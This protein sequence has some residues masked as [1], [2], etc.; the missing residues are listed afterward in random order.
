[1]KSALRGVPWLASLSEEALD[2]V[3]EAGTEVRVPPG[4]TLMGELEAGDDL[5]ILVEG[6]ARATVAAGQAA[7]LQLGTLGP[8][9]T[10]GELSLVTRELRS[11]TVTAE[12]ELQALRIERLEFEQLLRRH[13]QIAA[14]FAREVA[15]RL[16][17]ADGALDAML[18]RGAAAPEAQRLT[19]RMAAVT[20]T[21]GSLSRA[22]RELVVSRWREPPFLAL[23][24]FLITLVVIRLAVWAA[25]AAGVPLFALLRGAYTSGFAL[26]LISTATSLMRFRPSTRRW[27]A[28]GCGIGFALIVNELSVFLAFD[29]FYVD[30]TTRDPSMV[31]DVERLYRRSESQ[32]AIALIA[33]FLIQATY[34][35]RFYR[36]VG[37]ILAA[38]L[39]RTT[40]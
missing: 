4:Q 12:S 29:V 16:R 40:G 13:P 8:G 22:W 3:V 19:G 5:F 31:F 25:E 27:I 28:A 10:C 2:D 24:C 17:D 37:F 7:P 39:R 23:A 1:M 15:A 33:L 9:D 18:E 14:H 26:V 21:R 11:A 30:M 35:G 36:R 20:P 6:A 32:W 34:L 38:R